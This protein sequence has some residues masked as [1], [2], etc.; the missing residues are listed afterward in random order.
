MITFEDVSKQYPDGT[1]AVSG[2]N[3][4]APSGKLTVLVGPSGC[5]KTTT[6][7]MINRLV[8]PTGGRVLVGDQDTQTTDRVALRR[9]IGYVIQGAGLFPHRTALDNV[10]AFPR[11]LG[12]SKKAA[13]ESA[14]EL[15]TRV[16]LTER[17][18]RRY[19]WQL[20]GGQQQRVGVARALA[21]DPPFLLMDEPFSAVDP[22]VRNQL[23][24][25]FLRLQQELSKT[26]VMVT[27]DIDEALKLGDYV[28]VMR[29]GGHVAQF[30]TPEELLTR[31]ADQ[32]VA[33]FIGNGRGYRSLQ[34]HR[35]A[36]VIDTEWEEPVPV[37]GIPG[38]GDSVVVD[39]DGKP[40]GWA[41]SSGGAGTVVGVADIDV[42]GTVARESSSL[43]EL[44]DA[45]V[46]SP[47][48]RALIAGDDGRYK[49]TVRLSAVSA[50]METLKAP[51][52]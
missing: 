22:I 28:A 10:A 30:A 38:R 23:Q 45:A 24:D 33:D 2:L 1:V 15:L 5:G 42:S 40:L 32:F 44:F 34:F 43:R 37:G 41:R 26:I 3:F 35:W 27:H 52:A 7:R 46:S 39:V 9:R 49:G 31:P 51:V 47:T 14:M 50:A 36:H 4:V 6:M 21:T 20:S 17:H 16:G 12:A 13:R 11:L 18:A 48:G 8:D 25:E 29:E 19:P